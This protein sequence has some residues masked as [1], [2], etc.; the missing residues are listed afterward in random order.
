VSSLLLEKAYLQAR[1]AWPDVP[2]GR[3]AFFQHVEARVGPDAPAEAIAALHTDD[4]YLACACLQGERAALD[5]FERVHAD[6]IRHSL[7]RFDLS[8]G[9]RDDILQT[10]RVGFFIKKSL[11]GYSGRGVLRGWVRSAATRAALDVVGAH[12]RR[13]DDEEEILG[14]L[15]ATGDV[16]LDLIRGRFAA[17]FRAAFAATLASL[18]PEDRMLLVQHYV[19]DL[20]I[21]QLAAIQGVHRATAARRV[22]RLRE[23]LLEGTRDRLQATLSID[24]ATFDSLMRVAGSRLDVSVFRLLRE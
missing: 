6:A 20:S 4:L 1:Q 11:A 3:A 10:L 15:P 12:A 24:T 19:D 22:V 9:E 16:E 8:R 17:E 21:D 5:A 14:N 2:L 23:A 7:S 18:S 13:P